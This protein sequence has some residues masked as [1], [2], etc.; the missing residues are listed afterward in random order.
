MEIDTQMQ[1]VAI[2]GYLIS[3]IYSLAL[4]CIILYCISQLYLLVRASPW[5]HHPTTSGKLP[6]VTIQLPVYNE[7]YVVGRLIDCVCALDYPPDLLEIQVLDDST[8]ETSE[9]IRE[10]V[11]AY[12][13]KGIR[14]QHIRRPTRTGYKAGALAH[15]LEYASGECIAIFDADFL[16]AQDFL[17]QCVPYFNDPHIGVVQARWTH[18]NEG[19]S[20]LTRLQAFQLNVHFA[21]EQPGR[22]QSRLFLQFNGTAGVWRKAAIIDAGGWHA[23]TLTEDLDLSYRAQLRGWQ[24]RYLPHVVSPAELPAEMSSLKAQQFRWMKGGA[25]TARKLFFTTWSSGLT[26][27]KKYF[28]THHLLSSSIFLCVF[29]VA[30]LSIPLSYFSSIIPGMLRLHIIGL[31]GLVSTGMVYYVAN[32]RTSWRPDSRIKQVLSWLWMF[33][34]FLALSMGLSF[35]NSVAVLQGLF[36]RIS[37]FVRTPKSSAVSGTFTGSPHQYLNGKLPMG[38]W[39]EGLLSLVF[40]T[41]AISGYLSEQRLFVIFHIVLAAGFGTICFFSIH[42][43]MRAGRSSEQ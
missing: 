29:I 5:R 31:A 8:D 14:I 26:A 39:A 34:V 22:A 6:S 41:S 15:G 11:E 33:P 21:V 36:G 35:H 30:L 28:A 9:I 1:G 2:I 19:H 25:E 4:L 23:D 16:P 32:A 18:L 13:S 12:W 10:K 17:R 24:I 7:R 40:L 27:V 20:I 37:P 38:T 42:H 43:H 3:V